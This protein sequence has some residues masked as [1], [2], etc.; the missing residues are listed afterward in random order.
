MKK[1][2]KLRRLFPKWGWLPFFVSILFVS[3]L[4]AQNVERLDDK[5]ASD[6]DGTQFLHELVTNIN[7][8][9]YVSDGDLNTYG[10]GLPVV[11]DYK[12]GGFDRLYTE[13]E[14]FS[15]V[16]LI[17]IKVNNSNELQNSLNLSRLSGFKNLEYVVVQFTFDVCENGS[18]DCIAPLV[19]KMISETYQNPVSVLYQLSIA[20]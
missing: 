12:S 5:F 20:N 14:L 9:V 8:T 13:D 18:D 10:D 4:S 17:I 2:F 7:P 16:K 3:Q 11:L 6:P 1:Y 19:Q 15:K